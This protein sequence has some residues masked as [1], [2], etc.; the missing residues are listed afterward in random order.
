MTG[1]QLYREQGE[2]DFVPTQAFHSAPEVDRPHTAQEQIAHL[3][4]LCGHQALERGFLQSEVDLLKKPGICSHPRKT[5][6]N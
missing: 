6:P 4:R 2:A 1:A 3:E 5:C